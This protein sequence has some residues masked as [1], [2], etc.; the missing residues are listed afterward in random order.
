MGE[1][2]GGIYDERKRG[3]QGGKE[4]EKEERIEVS[5]RMEKGR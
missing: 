2:E 5:R 1:G 4:N 3:R